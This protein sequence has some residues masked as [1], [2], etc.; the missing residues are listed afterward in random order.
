MSK[1]YR[2]HNAEGLRRSNVPMDVAEASL[3]EAALGMSWFDEEYHSPD[4]DGR[5]M[6]SW[7]VVKDICRRLT[8]AS[9]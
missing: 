5:L 3:N 2:E 6:Y 9:N 8:A 7:A 1:T 4:T